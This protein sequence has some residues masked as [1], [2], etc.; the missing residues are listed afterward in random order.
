MLIAIVSLI[1]LYI[2]GT[3]I[4]GIKAHKVK[5]SSADDYFLAGRN[6]TWWHLGLTIFATWFSTFAFLGLPG[7]FYERGAKWFIACAT[8][9]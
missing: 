1:A 3:I 2:I 7:F 9:N 6:V 5:D 4:L 8:F